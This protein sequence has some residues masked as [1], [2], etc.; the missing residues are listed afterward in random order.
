MEP[1]VDAASQAARGDDEV[2]LPV[3]TKMAAASGVGSS[4]FS[5]QQGGEWRLHD[6]A[7][8]RED[9]S[10]AA[11]AEDTTKGESASECQGGILDWVL[12]LP[13]PPLS[14]PLTLDV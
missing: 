2:P 10:L 14:S 7:M 11:A 12:S 5:L 3:F 6:F 8:E 4:L 13:P 1:A 9:R